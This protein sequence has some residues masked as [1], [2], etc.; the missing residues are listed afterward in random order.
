MGAGSPWQV[1]TSRKSLVEMKAL[2]AL[3]RVQSVVTPR[4]KLGFYEE[5]AD[6]LIPA[7]AILM[8]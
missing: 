1:E 2:A 8:L 7:S 5:F 6:D 3:S 4:G